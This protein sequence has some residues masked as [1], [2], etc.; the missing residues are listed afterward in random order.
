MTVCQ[1]RDVS[2]ASGTL[3]N[4]RLILKSVSVDYLG[5]KGGQDNE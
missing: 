2:G 1:K 4:G 5:R 3:N